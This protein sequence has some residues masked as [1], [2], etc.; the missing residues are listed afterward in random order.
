MKPLGDN[1]TRLFLQ[2]A[3]EGLTPRQILRRLSMKL[4]LAS[5]SD[6]PRWPSPSAPK[7][8]QTETVA[9]VV[10]EIRYLYSKKPP[11]GWLLLANNGYFG[12][13]CS[14]NLG[15]CRSGK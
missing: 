2:A 14:G 15:G 12:T 8:K 5:L 6:T 3:I 4:K 9:A 10:P 7:C 11:W 13:V 1:E